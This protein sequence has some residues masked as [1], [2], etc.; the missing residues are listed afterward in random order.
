M[1]NG[2]LSSLFACTV[3]NV[4]ERLDLPT[5]SR[6]INLRNPS[7]FSGIGETADSKCYLTLS[8]SVGL[9]GVP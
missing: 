6:S 3:K 9:H 5:L 2:I 8:T 7:P 4:Q 1:T